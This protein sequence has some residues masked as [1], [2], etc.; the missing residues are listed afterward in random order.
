ME[1]IANVLAILYRRLPED[2]VVE[3]HLVE[4][5]TR[6]LNEQVGCSECEQSTQDEFDN[7]QNEVLEQKAYT[8]DQIIEDLKA[9]EYNIH[10]NKPDLEPVY[11]KYKPRT[12]LNYGRAMKWWFAQH[13]DDMWLSRANT[14]IQPILD[15]IRNRDLCSMDYAKQRTSALKIVMEMY[16]M[17]EQSEVLGAEIKC[18]NDQINTAR[19]IKK[20]QEVQHIDELNEYFEEMAMWLEDQ[21]PKL[22]N[23]WTNDHGLCVFV[24]LYLNYAVLRNSEVYD[25][26]I[27]DC[28][29]DGNHINLTTKEIVVVN[30]KNSV[31]DG[32]R[33]ISFEHDA[34]MNLL[35]EKGIGNYVISQTQPSKKGQPYKS[36][37]SIYDLLK[38]KLGKG[39]RALRH[40]KTSQVLNTQDQASIRELAHNQGHSVGVQNEYYLTA[41]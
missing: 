11:A 21:L 13:D 17:N 38:S 39:H 25:M 19:S 33:R 24:Y 5:A 35:C 30:H 26:T 40:A 14:N 3:K 16:G 2:A 36:A 41:V 8:Y 28:E 10:R 18:I 22:G 6:L 23:D 29:L 34:S 31:K 15:L 20:L 9:Y 32:T 1:E 37:T 12:V 4:I 7:L 27:S